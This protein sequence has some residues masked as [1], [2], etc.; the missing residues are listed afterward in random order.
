MTQVSGFTAG[1]ALSCEGDKYLMMT[2]EHWASLFPA[3]FS[4]V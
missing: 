3:L 4:P 2:E 1:R